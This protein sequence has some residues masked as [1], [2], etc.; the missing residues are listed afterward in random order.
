[1]N[2]KSEQ[3]KARPHIGRLLLGIGS[4]LL[5]IVFVPLPVPLGWFFLLVGVSLI[6]VEI[7]WVGHLVRWSRSRWGWGDRRLRQ[8]HGISPNLVKD[9]LDNTDPHV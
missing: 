4:V 9:F 2:Y 7:A 5:G 1:M 6:A 8:L 3:K